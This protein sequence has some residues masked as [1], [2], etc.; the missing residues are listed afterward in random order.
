LTQKHVRRDRT[1]FGIAFKTSDTGADR[2]IIM[3]DDTPSRFRHRLPHFRRQNTFKQS[4]HP[5]EIVNTKMVPR[6]AN[7][8]ATPV[9]RAAR[10]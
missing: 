10:M 6:K 3:M 2:F 5:S 8:D 1:F 4:E 9:F 7:F